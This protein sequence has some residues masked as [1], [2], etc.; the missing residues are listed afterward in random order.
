[1]SMIKRILARRKIET[2]TLAAFAAIST[3]AFMP[4]AYVHDALANALRSVPIDVKPASAARRTPEVKPAA[5]VQRKA[6]PKAKLVERLTMRTPVLPAARAALGLPNIE[7]P[8]VQSW[9]KRFTTTHRGSMAIYLQRKERYEPMISQKLAARDMPQGL[10][11]LAM[12]ESGFNPSARSPVKATGLWQFMAPT[13][14]QYG[15]KVGGRV[16]ERRNPARSTDAALKYLDALHRR[17]GSWY[18][19]AAAYNTGQGRVA[20]VLKQVTGKTRGT[21]ADYYRIAHRLP[22]ETRD[23][24]PKMV[25]AARIG[26]NP[27]RYGFSGGD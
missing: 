19:A 15:L 27:Q 9:I 21:D 25:A 20:R 2:A 10:I 23:Y 11:Y 7:H 8:R 1:M 13:A 24:V 4:N 6:A 18:L 16:D 3:F 5:Q 26:T 14:R 17:F 12:I 22:R